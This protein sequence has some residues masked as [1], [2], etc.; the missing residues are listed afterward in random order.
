MMPA[1]EEPDLAA[2]LKRDLTE[3]VRE[4]EA[5]SPRS[6]QVAIGASE[7][8][9]PCD[10]ALAL[11]SLGYTGDDRSDP[12]ARI[13]GTAVH[14]YLEKVYS[15]LGWVTERRV[16]VAPGIKGTADLYRRNTVIDHKV[17]ADT[18]MAKVKKG[19]ISE[20][21]KVQVQAYG[22]GFASLGYVV[23]NVAIAFWP[24]G[25][26]AWL[27]GL[28]VWT[29]VFRPEIVTAALNRWY[30]IANAA[31]EL[32]L[33]HHP[34]RAELIATADGPCNWC[35]FHDVTGRAPAPSCKG[36]GK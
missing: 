9:N 1:V 5:A 28:E 13:I 6:T 33:E 2:V 34:A 32:D 18:T 25:R 3:A 23:E 11:K 31:I 17:P 26:G 10:R 24:R 12:W 35:P 27:G 36:H 14:F 19:V 30:A 20:T 4:Y 7:L 29:D 16:E 8:G 22:V 21:Y 15:A